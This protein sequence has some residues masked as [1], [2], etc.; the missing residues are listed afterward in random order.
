MTE[1]LIICHPDEDPQKFVKITILEQCSDQATAREREAV[2]AF[3]LFS[4]IPSG[5]NIRDETSKI[6]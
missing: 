4:Y 6:K 1:H 3:K 5:L 2:W